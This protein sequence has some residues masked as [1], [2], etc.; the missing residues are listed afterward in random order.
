MAF[1]LPNVRREPSKSKLEFEN[2]KDNV[3]YPNETAWRKPDPER[4]WVKA[5]QLVKRKQHLADY[6]QKARGTLELSAVSNIVSQIERLDK[7]LK[8]MGC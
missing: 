4:S 1:D 3:L 8:K 5:S 6:L 2:R 7:E